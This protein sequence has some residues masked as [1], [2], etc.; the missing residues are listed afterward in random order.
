MDEDDLEDDD[1]GDGFD[2]DDSISSEEQNTKT[3]KKA[4]K[5]EMDKQPRGF[6]NASVDDGD[7]S[8]DE[9]I[10]EGALRRKL[11]EES[12]EEDEV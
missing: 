5:Q 4:R 7:S 3:K 9:E 6:D 10:S 8:A 1:A 11:V 2:L 12:D